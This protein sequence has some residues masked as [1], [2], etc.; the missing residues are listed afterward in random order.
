MKSTIKE[1][2][3]KPPVGCFVRTVVYRPCLVCFVSAF[4]A[5]VFVTLAGTSAALKL[6]AS[7]IDYGD[8]TVKQVFAFQKANA[9]IENI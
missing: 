4:I 9:E 5:L 6:G 3:D 2:K 1:D 7:W 8:M